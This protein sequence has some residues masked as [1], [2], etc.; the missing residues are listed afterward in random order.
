MDVLFVEVC[1]SITSSIVRHLYSYFPLY[2]FRCVFF[3]SFSSCLCLCISFVEN[4][5]TMFSSYFVVVETLYI[6]SISCFIIKPNLEFSALNVFFSP[7]ERCSF[8]RWNVPLLLLHSW[9]HVNLWKNEIIRTKILFHS[10][11]FPA[12]SFLITLIVFVCVLI[13]LQL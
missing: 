2:I 10:R 9:F 11:P 6:E 3:R 13:K 1:Y 4:I 12:F 5:K 8:S 7:L